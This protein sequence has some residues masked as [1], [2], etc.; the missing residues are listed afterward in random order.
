MIEKPKIRGTGYFDYFEKC[1]ICKKNKMVDINGECEY[2]Y[3][4][5]N[6]IRK[7]MGK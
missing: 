5:M 7:E 1:E 6:K 2:C 4:E 3:K